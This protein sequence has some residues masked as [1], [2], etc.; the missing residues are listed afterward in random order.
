MFIKNLSVLFSF[1]SIGILFSVIVAIMGARLLN[2]SELG[3]YN[4]V[5]NFSNLLV[6]PLAF[7]VNTTLLKILPENPENQR[8]TILGTVALCNMFLCCLITL[9]YLILLPY[10]SFSLKLSNATC[11][12]A[13]GTAIISNFCILAETLLKNQ[14][15]FITIGISKLVGALVVFLLYLFSLKYAYLIS[16]NNFLFYNIMGQLIIF[17]MMS[18]KTKTGKLRFTLSF[19]KSIYTY[20]SINM[21]SWL[22]TTSLYSIDIYILSYFTSYYEVGIYSVYQ[23]MLRNFF[24]IFFNDIFAAVFVP[25]IVALDK[26][27]VN[28]YKQATKVLP[29][30]F[31]I[32]SLG[33]AVLSCVLIYAY[34]NQYTLNP[35]YVLLVAI[36]IGLHG[37]YLG[38][39][40]ILIIE[41]IVGAKISLSVLGK[42][43]ILL[44]LIT[45][46]FTY[47]WGI[48][49]TFLAFIVNQVILIFRLFK[50]LPKSP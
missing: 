18:I 12:F 26:T 48:V 1:R 14:Q 42:P 15:C 2:V 28:L 9:I 46:L 36:G 16:I 43:F 45:V 3:K 11:F 40:S 6:I 24:S 49:G 27:K 25:T 38:L 32:I 30:V 34:G 7:G 47:Y 44:I 5:I 23:V 39:N 17:L 37:V 8:G 21:V 50:L 13:I 22:F 20:S 10:I 29:F 31:I 33:T 35:L 4:L 19:A 41:G